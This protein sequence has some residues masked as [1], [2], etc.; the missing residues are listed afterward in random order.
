MKQG[1]KGNKT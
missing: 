1:T